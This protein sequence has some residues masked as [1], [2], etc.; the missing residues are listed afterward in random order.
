[1]VTWFPGGSASLHLVKAKR[2]GLH[3]STR[4][5]RIVKQIAA[6]AQPLVFVENWG[7]GDFLKCSILAPVQFTPAVTITRRMAALTPALRTWACSCAK[8]CVSHPG[9]KANQAAEVKK[10]YLIVISLPK[11]LPK[12][13]QLFPMIPQSQWDRFIKDSSHHMSEN[14]IL[15]TELGLWL[16]EKGGS[17]MDT[18]HKIILTELMDL[19]TKWNMAMAHEAMLADFFN[20][21]RDMIC[22][23]IIYAAEK[24]GLSSIT[25]GWAAV[26]KPWGT[27]R[28]GPWWGRRG[29]VPTGVIP[30]KRDMCIYA[31]KGWESWFIPI[32]NVWMY[33][34]ALSRGLTMYVHMDWDRH[35]KDQGKVNLYKY[36]LETCWQGGQDGRLY[37]YTIIHMLWL[38]KNFNSFWLKVSVLWRKLLIDPVCLHHIHTVL[39]T[40][41]TWRDSERFFLSSHTTWLLQGDSAHPCEAAAKGCG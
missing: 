23:W 31:L 38:G 24:S 30:H 26:L 20:Y 19:E 4:R 35:K 10:S 25:E 9:R 3:T 6:L 12:A 5:K 34:D 21:M 39:F 28:S 16:E 17:V 7:C 27:G 15:S 14:W 36:L 32:C 33:P 13:S 29:C 37:I 8:Y 40:C 18:A 22:A 11:Q 41:L 1:M 2:M